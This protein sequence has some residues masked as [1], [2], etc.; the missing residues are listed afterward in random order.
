MAREWL[1]IT[2]EPVTLSFNMQHKEFEEGALCVK[3]GNAGGVKSFFDHF[4]FGKE[5][6]VLLLSN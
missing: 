5:F 6:I 1:E 2:R 4:I 3:G